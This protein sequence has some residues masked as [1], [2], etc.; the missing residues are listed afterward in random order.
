MKKLFFTL[1]TLCLC[2]TTWAYDF[3][4]DNIYYTIVDADNAQ[5][6]V[7]YGGSNHYT[8]TYSGTLTIPDTVTNGGNTYTVVGVGEYGA[9]NA[10]ITSVS[11]GQNVTYIGKEAFD[12]SSLTSVEIP[13]NVVTIGEEAFYYCHSLATVVIE[14]S[15]STTIGDEAFAHCDA[16][17]SV[18]IGDGVTYIGDMAFEFCEALTTVS[19]GKDVAYIGDGAFGDCAITNFTIAEG[20]EYYVL[21]TDEYGG[22]GILYT[23]DYTVLVQDLYYSGESFEIPMSVTKI[24]MDAFAKSTFSSITIGYNIEEIIDD[25]FWYCENLTTVIVLNPVPPTCGSRAF[26]SDDEIDVEVPAG[27]IDFY[28]QMW[29]EEIDNMSFSELDYAVIKISLSDGTNGYATYYNTDYDVTLPEGV[30]AYTI[31]EVDADGTITME[32]VTTTTLPAQT[33]VVLEGEVGAYLP[34]TVSTETTSFGG[35]NMLYSREITADAYAPDE[36]SADDYYFFVLSTV[37]GKN[38]GFH[39]AVDGGGVFSSQANRAWLPVLKD[40]F[41]S[42]AAPSSLSMTFGNTTGISSIESDSNAKVNGIYTIQGVRVSNTNQ[43]GLYIV[44]GKKVLVK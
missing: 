28:E 17:T 25:T 10:S 6:E 36:G 33:A 43:P 30:K 19:I 16:L 23:S 14:G 44:E 24:G 5:V 38:L 11:F 15:G 29:G 9:Y 4:V 42:G 7:T 37:N 20:N 32:E 39:V 1:L 21:G 31:S 26:R 12:S 2:G 27:T 13:E 35:T 3:V 34:V 18:E 8:S 41:P 40:T 22:A